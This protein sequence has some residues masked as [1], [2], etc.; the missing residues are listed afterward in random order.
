M[1]AIKA[2]PRLERFLLALVVLALFAG[3]VVV[4]SF[5]I[6]PEQNKD[7]VIQLVGGVNTLAGLV[8]GWYFGRH[9][10]RDEIVV[11]QADRPDPCRDLPQPQFGDE[12]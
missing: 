2:S 1:K 11:D 12:G 9:G 5:F 8:V 3:A 6:V 4:M 7:V 10:D